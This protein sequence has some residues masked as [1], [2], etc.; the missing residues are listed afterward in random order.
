MTKQPPT[1]KEDMD[2]H[3]LGVGRNQTKIT[4]Q[5]TLLAR[6]LGLHNTRRSWLLANKFLL[7]LFFK[8]SEFS[9]FS[10]H[11]EFSPFSNH[12]EFPP[13]FSTHEKSKGLI[14]DFVHKPLVDFSVILYP[15]EMRGIYRYNV[16][17]K[18]WFGEEFSHFFRNMFLPVCR[19]F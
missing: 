13:L 1:L 14:V 9:L 5:A 4:Q 11:D 15:Q 17:F 16:N 7:L 18:L 10:N 8:E 6:P 2:A 12:V 3:T 19:E